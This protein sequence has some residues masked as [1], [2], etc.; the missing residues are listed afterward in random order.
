MSATAG[1]AGSSRPRGRR[2]GESGTRKAV[3]DAAR[4]RFAADGYTGA[5]IRKIATDAGVDAAL[6]MRFY[7]SKDDLFAAAMVIPP[8]AAQAFS[9]ALDGPL[10]GIGDRLVRAFLRLWTDED[11]AAPLL[12]TFRSAVTNEQAAAQ[13]RAFIR[14]RLL[15]VF[16][17]RFPDVVDAPLRATLASSTLLGVVVG[18]QIVGIDA[19]VDAEFEDIVAILAPVVQQILVP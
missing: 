5:S 8:D 4:L 12:A 9:E 2:P 19:L 16:V 10:D 18:R 1:A 15:E 17:P 13:L 3:L 7:G 6:V 14:A 11:A